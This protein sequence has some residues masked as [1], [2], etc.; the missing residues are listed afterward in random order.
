VLVLLA[1]V[2]VNAIGISV[3]ER[4]TEMAV[5]KALGFR[6][7]QILLLVLGEALLL[8]GASGLGAAA[9]AYGGA[10]FL[11]PDAEFLFLDEFVVPFQALW[12]GPAVGALTA[13]VGGLGPAWSARTVKVA[14]VFARVVG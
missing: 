3:R 2:V 9:L 1:L 7:G 12:W 8:G 13:L 5:L 11:F 14:D 10:Q 4:L 6:P